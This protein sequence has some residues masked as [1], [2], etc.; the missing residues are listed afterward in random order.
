MAM[1]NYDSGQTFDSGVLYDAVSPPQPIRRMQKVKVKLD[2]K[3]K[4][5][6][7][8]L[9]FSQ[10]HVSAMTANDNFTTPLPDE[11]SYLAVQ[12]AYSTALGDFNTKQAAAKQA[13]TV[14]DTAR[15]ALEGMI[16][17]R[18]NYVELTAAGADDPA[19]VIESAGFSVKSAKTPAAVPVMVSNLSITGGDNAGELDLQWDPANGAKTYD[20]ELS[21]EP[22]TSTSWVAHPSVTKSKA[23]ILGLTSGAKMWARVRGVGPGGTGAWSDPATKIVP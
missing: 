20:V 11:T 5:D 17:Q 4:S 23:V 14:K 12:T 2:L 8:L 9:T 6:S 15:L 13:T 1:A 19:A 7:D 10:A 18:G 21:P 3:S 16:S 22:I